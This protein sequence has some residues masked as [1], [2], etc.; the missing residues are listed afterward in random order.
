MGIPL[1][2]LVVHAVVVLLP[3][4]ALGAIVLVAVPRWR[5]TFGPLVLA[6]LLVSAASAFAAKQSGQALAAE[7][8]ITQQHEQWGDRLFPISLILLVVFTAWW[9]WQRRATDPG[10]RSA[11][12][13]IGGILTV[14]VAL[15]AIGATIVTGHSGAEAA[16]SDVLPGD[17]PTPTPTPTA[18]GT[19]SP[20]STPSPTSGATEA[21]A[22]TLADV[23]AH[24][25][26]DD[27]WSAIN[28][29]VYDLSSWIAQHPGGS[30]VIIGLCGIDGTQGFFAQ[31]DGQGAPEAQLAS[32][33]VGP[34]AP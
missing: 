4:S 10:K 14:I 9:L 30:E 29:N 13:I 31:H 33:L 16:W 23:A 12:T 6:G 32:L 11:L 8:G 28:G 21:A 24:A 1:H 19:P 27:C 22:L 5:K 34:L 26:P 15:G 2:P 20:S 3:L 25:S 17:T 18:T 7:I